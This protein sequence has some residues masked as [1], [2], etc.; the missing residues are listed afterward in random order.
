MTVVSWVFAT[1]VTLPLF[2]WYLTY[3]TMV[4]TTKN[5]RK[6]VRVASDWSMIWFVLAVYYIGVELWS[7]SFFWYILI[8]LFV[9]AIIFTWLHWSIAQDIIIS[10]LFKGIWRM[11]FLIFLLLYLILSG[12]GLI[13][14][15]FFLN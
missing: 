9:I 12:Y 15:I 1:F 5:K 8:I 13:S 10:K 3:I 6:S 14:R 7:I 4:K 2:A 11:N